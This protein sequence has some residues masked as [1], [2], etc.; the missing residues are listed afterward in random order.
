M[1]SK[2]TPPRRRL[3]KWFL[4]LIGIP[5]VLASLLSLLPRVTVTVSDPV[6]PEDPFSSSV[7]ITNTGYIPLKSVT[8]LLGLGEI[9]MQG[10]QS[11]HNPHT[12]YAMFQSSLLPV[13]D[14]G[15]D[16]KFT[17]AIND[18]WKLEKPFVYADIAV[19]VE[20]HIPLLPFWKGRKTFPMIAHKQSN[21]RFYWYAKTM[22]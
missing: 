9:D 16:D 14:L 19:V 21:G 22:S 10:S 4:F 13:Q 5:G 18:P 7:T 6:V 15:L 12:R 20:Y 17:F 1:E 8:P 11:R 3:T 2:K